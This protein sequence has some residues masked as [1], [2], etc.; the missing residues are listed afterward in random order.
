[1]FFSDIDQFDLIWSWW[2]AL[3]KSDQSKGQWPKVTWINFPNFTSP[4]PI[5]GMG[6]KLYPFLSSQISFSPQKSQIRS[7]TFL[8]WWSFPT[9]HV[10][11]MKLF[12][13]DFF[14]NEKQCVGFYVFFVAFDFTNWDKMEKL[15]GI[16]SKTNPITW[17]Q[18][19]PQNSLKPEIMLNNI[20]QYLRY[21][22]VDR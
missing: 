5:S 16:G 21:I 17:K 2:S 22:Y 3:S 20:I 10:Q 11:K 14:S 9:W 4:R 6:I 13:L 8:L 7:F 15:H 19:A 12:Y 18:V 1:M